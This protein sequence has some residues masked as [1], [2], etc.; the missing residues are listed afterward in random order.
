MQVIEIL[1]ERRK[2]EARTQLDTSIYDVDR[3]EKSRQLRLAQVHVS[4]KNIAYYLW[5]SKFG[6][7]YELQNKLF[8]KIFV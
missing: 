2:E 4:P 7:V 8:K 1:N 3:N 5:I 6:F